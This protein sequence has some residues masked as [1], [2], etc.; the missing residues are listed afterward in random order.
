MGKNKLLNLFR[1]QIRCL[2]L[3]TF[4]NSKFNELLK[5]L[6]ENESKSKLNISRNSI[7]VYCCWAFK[8]Q[9]GKHPNCVKYT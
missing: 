2:Y 9:Y 3:S 7:P 1:I 4:R 5:L 6:Q 8:F